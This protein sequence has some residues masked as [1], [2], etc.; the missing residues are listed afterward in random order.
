MNDL[1]ERLRRGRDWI[2]GDDCDA[3]ADMLEAHT[4]RLAAIEGI[5]HSAIPDADKI[6]GIAYCLGRKFEG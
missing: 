1:T 4:A 6:A 5:V 2:S 3:I